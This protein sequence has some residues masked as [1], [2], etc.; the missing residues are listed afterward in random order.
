MAAAAEPRR[1]EIQRALEIFCPLDEFFHRLHRRRWI[2]HEH[3]A[4]CRQLRN[5]CEVVHRVVGQLWI[6]RRIDGVLMVRHEQRVA[7]GWRI[8]NDFRSDHT[9]GAGAVIDNDLLFQ[10]LGEFG[11]DET[12]EDV[13]GAA[14]C[15]RGDQSDRS[16]GITV[17]RQ[18]RQ[19]RHQHQHNSACGTEC[20]FHARGS[21]N[22]RPP[23]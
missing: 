10:R 7:V 17:L 18:H 16:V 3:Q 12:R 6:H 8:G 23:I 4:R 15:C 22:D 5:R 19:C 14:G 21:L 1:A 20:R 2:D 9:R 13:R 11:A